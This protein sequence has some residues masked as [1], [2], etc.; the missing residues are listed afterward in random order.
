MIDYRFLFP[1]SQSDY[2]RYKKTGTLLKINKL[3]PV[4][5]NQDYVAYTDYSL[6][7]T[8]LN[9]KINYNHLQPPSTTIQTVFGMERPKSNTCSTFEV[10]SN[11]N[12]R[13]NRVKMF[14]TKITP[15]PVRK[16]V[17]DS[18]NLRTNYKLRC[19]CKD[20]VCKCST[21]CP[22]PNS[23]KDKITVKPCP[24]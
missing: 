20:S 13:T 8:V 22:C 18:S 16:Y 3:D 23:S 2:I 1:M 9:T 11:T 24:L 6:E 12:N 21:L 5:S 15:R 17:K 4:I 10:C 14:G 19:I 7:N